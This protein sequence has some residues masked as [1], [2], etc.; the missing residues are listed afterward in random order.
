MKPKK[1]VAVFILLAVAGLGLSAYM[2]ESSVS[3]S[4][5]DREVTIS[6]ST[7]TVHTYADDYTTKNLTVSTVSDKTITVRLK[8]I[9]AD[10]Q[11]AKAWGKDFIAIISPEEVKINSTHEAKVTLITHSEKAGNY[12][13]KVI[14]V[15]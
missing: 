15:K 14:A 9:P 12:R 13:V 6:P 2:A 3:L 1:A 10:Y 5:S 7:S 4:V 11:T 8:A